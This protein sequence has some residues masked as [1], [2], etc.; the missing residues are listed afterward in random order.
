MAP[1]DDDTKMLVYEVYRDDAAFDVHRSGA[2]LAQ[3]REETAG[4]IAKFSI[5]R[6]TPVESGA[7]V[8]LT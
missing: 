8:T 2:S 4:M 5:T 1:R 3:W 7:S 6:C